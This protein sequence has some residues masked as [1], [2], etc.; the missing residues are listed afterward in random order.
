MELVDKICLF[1]DI[2]LLSLNSF[3]A[4]I[5]VMKILIFTIN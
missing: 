5:C 3:L 1:L 4:N 2:I